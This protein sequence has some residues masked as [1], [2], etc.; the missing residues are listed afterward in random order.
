MAMLTVSNVPPGRLDDVDRAETPWG[1]WNLPLRWWDD[2]DRVETLP[3]ASGTVWDVVTK[4][5]VAAF[6]A[7]ELPLDVFGA[8][9]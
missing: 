4:S 7:T 1:V 3:G 5:N 8:L 2:V 6:L 9:L